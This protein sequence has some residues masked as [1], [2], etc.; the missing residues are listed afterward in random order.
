MLTQT[1]SSSALISAYSPVGNHVTK[2][3]R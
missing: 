2:Q 1:A 3:L